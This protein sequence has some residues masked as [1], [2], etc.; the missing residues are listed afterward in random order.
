MWDWRYKALSD[1]PAIV[2]VARSQ[3]TAEVV[4]H[5][6]MFRRHFRIGDA[7]LQFC[8]PGNLL[9][10]PD[11]QKN[12]V[13][14]RLVMIVRSLVQTREF[15]AVLA[16]AN[17]NAN[18]MFLRLG[19]TELGVMHTYVDVRDAGP[20]LRR[21]KRAL[22]VVAPLVNL[23][24]AARRLLSRRPGQGHSDL[25]VRKLTSD[26]FVGFD[27]SHWAPSKRL[28]AW[29]SNQFVVDRYLNEPHA[30]RH[31]YGLVNPVTSLLEGYVVTEPTAR[32]KVWD[33]QTNPATIDPTAAIRAVVAQWPNAET[34]LVP[35]LPHSRL[36]KDLV[37][38]GFLDRESVDS[39]ESTTYL[40]AYS[41]PDHPHT[42]ALADPT[43]WDIWLGSRH[44]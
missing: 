24:F 19:F 11:W 22:A 31:L 36:A 34:V 28:V 12:I 40:S 2:Y 14:V 20:P 39:T 26:Q 41:L 37:R 6:A 35:T 1:G 16:F 4:G 29:D 25:R 21:R 8:V 10:H 44:Y 9:V 30:E 18:T 5:I 7:S 43:C 3:P 33:C 15:D 38:A 27:R 13:G 32:I 17:P 42:E 23:G